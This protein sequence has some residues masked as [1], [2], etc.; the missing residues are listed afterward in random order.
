MGISKFIEAMAQEAEL[1]D[2]ISVTFREHE[3]IIIRAEA[4]A[5]ELGVSRSDILREAVRDGVVRMEGEW[6][7][8]LEQGKKTQGKKNASAKR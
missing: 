4:L 2:L 8:A 1:G 3:E 6:A 7:R 5:V